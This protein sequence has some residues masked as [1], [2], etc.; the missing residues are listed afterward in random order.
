MVR[1]IFP[2]FV[3]LVTAAAFSFNFSFKRAAEFFLRIHPF[4]PACYSCHLK[5]LISLY[6]FMKT[7][8]GLDIFDIRHYFSVLG[9]ERRGDTINRKQAAE[10]SFTMLTYKSRKARSR[11]L[12]TAQKAKKCI[13]I[14]SSFCYLFPYFS[15]LTSH[16]SLSVNFLLFSPPPPSLGA[17][18]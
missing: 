1:Y 5:S 15:S 9:S 6:N 2:C 10:Q 17:S 11:C 7:T 16:F 3:V 14:A 8:A 18:F 4:K 13:Q 12:V